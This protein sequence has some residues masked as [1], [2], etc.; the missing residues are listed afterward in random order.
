MPFTKLKK[1]IIPGY[2]SDIAAN[3]LKKFGAGEKVTKAVREA[4]IRL[5]SAPIIGGALKA[6]DPTMKYG[7]LEEAHWVDVQKKAEKGLRAQRMGE[8]LDGLNINVTKL[9]KEPPTPDLKKFIDEGRDLLKKYK[10]NWTGKYAKRDAL[11]FNFI[12]KYEKGEEIPDALKPLADRIKEFTDTVWTELHSRGLLKKKQYIERYFPRYFVNKSTGEIASV[13][14]KPLHQIERRFLKHRV[15]RTIDEA[16]KHG[17]EPVRPFDNLKIYAGAVNKSLYSY[18]LIKTLVRKFGAKLRP[19]KSGKLPS[20]ETLMRRFGEKYTKLHH[21]MFKDWVVPSSIGN[22]LNRID[23]VL[24]EEKELRNLIKTANAIN[25]IWKKSATIIWPGFHLRNFY[26]NIWTLLFKDGIGAYTVR[27]YRKA[28]KIFKNPYSD[29]VIKIFNPHT[30]KWVK[31]PIRLIYEQFRRYGIH[32]GGWYATELGETLA[33]P[34][35][36]EKVAEKLGTVPEGI[37]RTYRGFEKKATHFGSMVENTARMASA[38]NDIEKGFSLVEA[39]RRVNTAFINYQ[40]ITKVEEKIRKIIPFWSWLRHNFTN[41]LNYIV[42]R[43]GEYMMFTIHPLKVINWEDEETAKYKPDWAKEQMLV[44]PFGLNVG[45][46]PLMLNPNLPFQDIGKL[47]INQPIRS[48]GRVLVSGVTPLIKTPIE[49]SL[50]KS[51]F[52][53]RPIQYDERQ[54]EKAPPLIEP[55]I[56]AMPERVRRRLGIVKTERGWEIPA[57]W[58]YTLIN[59]IP[60][61]K[62][63]K[64]IETLAHP[65]EA[66][67]RQRRAPF[68]IASRTTGIKF[69]PLDVKGYYKG[70]ALAERLRELKGLINKYGG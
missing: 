70:K 20:K 38:L 2:R 67:Y 28:M 43:P 7:K 30:G 3:I 22:A 19:S 31:K 52:T 6:F 39:A 50:N 47:V 23:L 41:Q 40:D 62:V 55:I 29:E 12:H 51:Y 42:T 1:Q 54:T 64:E 15:F 9:A 17:F 18:D 48:I 68:N 63:G 32:T 37:V 21:P 34:T 10:L 46:V 53:G 14:A 56:L 44:Q 24:T 66:E 8:I 65:L 33:K 36:A 45:G 60:Q 25:N 59:V 11:L 5:Q 49:T 26:S 57:K 35:L 4:P 69:Y 16:I 58:A 61:M 27:N 13:T